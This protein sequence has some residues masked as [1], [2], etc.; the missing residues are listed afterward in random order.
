MTFNNA[1]DLYSWQLFDVTCT[2]VNKVFTDS[3]LTVVANWST[4]KVG[5]RGT[6]PRNNLDYGCA[7]PVVPPLNR[8]PTIIEGH[9]YLLLVNHNSTT[10]YG[11][12][13]V[14]SGGTAVISETTIPTL[15][16]ASAKCMSPQVVVK[17]SKMVLASSIAANSSD[18]KINSPSISI[19]KATPLACGNGLSADSVVLTLS[20]PLPAGSY[21]IS[22]KK[23]SDN[24][25]ILD[26]CNNAIVQGN[27][28]DFDL[29]AAKAAI[30]SPLFGCPKDSV[31]FAD[32]S[33]GNVISWEWDFNN[34]N[35]ST[36]KN[37][38]PQYYPAVSTNTDVPVRLVV[39]DADNCIDT[40]YSILKLINTCYIAVPTAFTPNKDGLNDY[41]YPINA[42]KAKELMFRIYNRYGQVIFETNDWTKKWDGTIKGADQPFGNYVWTLRY[43]DEKGK[44]IFLK[45]TT[46]LIR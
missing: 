8:M 9:D 17:L 20:K 7:L 35:T 22:I 2:D 37:P 27:S 30:N 15:I 1:N 13:L 43:I 39:K 16:S 31:V 19:I 34:G 32:A 29:V 6:A 5:Y 24:N 18:F 12:Q 40:V 42:W 26:F 41:L 10:D 11:Y 25:T 44:K 4:M 21:S 33:T 3:N 36:V 46:A 28:V 45:G 14:V 38:P 23:G